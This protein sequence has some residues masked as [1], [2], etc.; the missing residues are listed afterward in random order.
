M[1]LSDANTIMEKRQE[2][3]M[4]FWK[5][6]L[7]PLYK[8][9]TW[10]LSH[11]TSK[12]DEQDMIDTSV[13]V[14]TN[15]KANFSYGLLC[16]ATPVLTEKQAHQFCADIGCSLENLPRT[17]DDRDGWREKGREL[18]WLVFMT[19]QPLLFNAKSGLYIHI[20]YIWFGLVGFYGI[21]TIVGYLMPNPV[22]TYIL[23]I[24]DL[25]WL[26]FITYQPL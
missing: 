20:R 25:V 11:K 21:S 15:S 2:F 17:M 8:T 16:I 18:V 23:D 14:S 13:E 7:A 4:I 26:G 24:Y 10:L 9:A 3:Y 22:Y 12:K 1:Y 6:W 5:I 19:Y